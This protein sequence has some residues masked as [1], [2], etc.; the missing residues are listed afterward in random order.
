ML[1]ATCVSS[2]T[3]I[4]EGVVMSA[5][6]MHIMKTLHQL[7]TRDTY[8]TIADSI[9]SANEER[10]ITDSIADSTA[11]NTGPIVGQTSVRASHWPPF[12]VHLLFPL[13]RASN[14]PTLQNTHWSNSKIHTV[15]R[16]SGNA[17]AD[18]A[19]LPLWRIST[20]LMVIL[21][22]KYAGEFNNKRGLLP[23]TLS[24]RPSILPP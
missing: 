18:C 22:Q 4:H 15:E 3:D 8:S 9:Y 23:F 20:L 13:E 10:G 6:L 11:V 2:P 12:A 17:L 16:T 7:H 5:I 24:L 14:P 21:F 1:F 19:S